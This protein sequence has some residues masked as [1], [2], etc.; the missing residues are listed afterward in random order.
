ME[1]LVDTDLLRDRNQSFEHFR[2]SYRKNEAIEEN[3]ATLKEKYGAAK[4]LAAQVNG[5]RARINSLKGT[6]EQLRK[7]RAAQGLLEDDDVAQ[8][9]DP[10]EER[11]KAEI[12]VEKVNY[13]RGYAEL[14]ALKGEIGNVRKRSAAAYL[15]DLF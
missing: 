8:E 14:K 2:K 1:T 7:E 5:T 3:K 12:D 13:K 10:E 4:S 9:V 15:M 11:A 6:I